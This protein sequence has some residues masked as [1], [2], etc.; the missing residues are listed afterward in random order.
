[1]NSPSQRGSLS[2]LDREDNRS[3]TTT[4]ATVA[5]YPSHI[6]AE[7]ALKEL[8]GAG[9]EMKRLSIIGCDYHTDDHVVWY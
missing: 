2:E 5:I 3:T 9:F 7:V 8:Q 6:E 1:M 4:H